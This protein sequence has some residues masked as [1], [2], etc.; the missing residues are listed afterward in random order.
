[1]NI[2]R[3]VIITFAFY[4]GVLYF[5]NIIITKIDEKNKVLT[6]IAEILMWIFFIGLVLSPVL[7]IDFGQPALGM[8]GFGAIFAVI[9][10]MVFTASPQEQKNMNK[11]DSK[12]H[13]I[14]TGLLS[15]I[16]LMIMLISAIV[17]AEPETWQN[18][19]NLVIPLSLLAIFPVIGIIMLYF[20]IKSI[21][22]PKEFS[23]E[24]SATCVELKTELST[25]NDGR[26]RRRLLY[27]PIYEYNY[28]GR[29]YK[30]CDEI[31]TVK[32]DCTKEG[33]DIFIKIDPENPYL[34]WD[35]KRRK[36]TAKYFLLL[37]VMFTIAGSIGLILFLKTRNIF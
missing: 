1:M 15:I 8:F 25:D 31:Y 24:I 22:T 12:Q 13:F 35:T 9:G 32:C 26:R 3:A 19:F 28:N 36:L 10:G 21:K 34:F 33:K 14:M 4:F 27:S 5:L 2:A 30:V 16:G 18:M 7:F 17:H 20:G 6:K 29:K 11:F 37:G 23:V